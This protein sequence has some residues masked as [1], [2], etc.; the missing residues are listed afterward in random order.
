MRGQ[1]A[2]LRTRSATPHDHHRGHHLACGCPADRAAH[3]DR[4][5][6]TEGPCTHR[7]RRGRREPLADAGVPARRRVRIRARRDGRRRQPL[8]RLRGRDRRL[9]DRALP[10]EGG[11]GHQ[12]SGGPPHPYRRDRLLRAALP[13]V[14]GAPRRA[15]LRSAR[16]RASSSPTRAPRPSRAP[17]SSPDTTPIGP[18]S[19]PSRAGSTAARWARCH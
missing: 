16:R 6:R 1:D 9:L 5:A 7:A 3:P 18:G 8:P 14:H 4:A 10:S 11:A 12:G 13:G 15:S 19:S 2:P 17:S